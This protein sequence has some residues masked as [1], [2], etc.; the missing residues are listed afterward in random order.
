MSYDPKTPLRLPAGTRI[1]ITGWFD[2]SARNK[3]NPD[4]A[5][6]VRYGEPTYDEMLIGFLDYV[7]EKPRQLA[8]VDAKVFDTYVGKYNFTRNRIYEITREGNRY[9]GRAP[10]NPKREL[11]PASATKF[12]IP[13]TETQINFVRNDKGEIELHYEQNENIIRCQRIKENP[14]AGGQQS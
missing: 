14:A 11:F 13:E 8:Q 9:F 2:N 1:Q 4:P 10:G 12:F 3:F 6:T 5:Q 7:S